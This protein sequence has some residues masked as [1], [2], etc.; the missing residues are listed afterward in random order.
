MKKPTPPKEVT[1]LYYLT[2]G[3]WVCDSTWPNEA[4]AVAW[5]K[6]YADGQGACVATYTLSKTWDNLAKPPATPKRKRELCLC[7]YTLDGRKCRT[8]HDV[9]PKRKKRSK[10]TK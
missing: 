3:G 2:N 6:E 8:Q 1:H 5:A 9:K 4:D 7:G 10:T